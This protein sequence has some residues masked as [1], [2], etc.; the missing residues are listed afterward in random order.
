MWVEP[1]VY[2]GIASCSQAD[3]YRL[4]GDAERQYIFL[5]KFASYVE[6]IPDTR[7]FF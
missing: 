7:S 1:D 6:V 4:V 5:M 3:E 2:F